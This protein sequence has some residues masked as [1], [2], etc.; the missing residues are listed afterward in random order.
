MP[1]AKTYFLT[2]LPW[3]NK[4]DIFRPYPTLAPLPIFGA[5]GII[6]PKFAL[7]NFKDGDEP[8]T[9]LLMPSKALPSLAGHGDR[10]ASNLWMFILHFL[11]LFLP[12]EIVNN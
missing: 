3:L 2:R 9:A 4:P 12:T 7:L 5:I 1:I 6:T 11:F 8:K 10:A